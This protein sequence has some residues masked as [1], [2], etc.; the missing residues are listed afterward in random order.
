MFVTTVAL[1]YRQNNRDLF[2]RGEYLQLQPAG[3]R[4]RHVVS[5][6]RRLGDKTAIVIATRFFSRLTPWAPVGREA[7]GDTAILM[8]DELAGCYRDVFT[9]RTVRARKRPAGNEDREEDGGADGDELPVAEALAHLPVA[10]L[11]RV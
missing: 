4:E 9:G 10:L 11:E 8:G 5:F 7:W 2:E 3:A 1:N 6:A